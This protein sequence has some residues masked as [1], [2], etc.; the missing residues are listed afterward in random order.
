MIFPLLEIPVP[1]IALF[2]GYSHNCNPPSVNIEIESPVPTAIC[3][4]LG[5]VDNDHIDFP[6]VCSHSTL[7]MELNILSLQSLPPHTTL[8][9]LPIIANP[10]NPS[11]ICFSHIIDPVLSTKVKVPLRSPTAIL[12]PSSEHA[13]HI[14]GPEMSKLKMVLLIM[15]LSL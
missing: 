13:I 3:C 1:T 15:L 14:T 12:F 4:P 7:P 10:C 2:V 6:I 5:S 9:P 8:L 11:S